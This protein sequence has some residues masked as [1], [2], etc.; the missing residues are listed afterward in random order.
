MSAGIADVAGVNFPDPSGEYNLPVLQ[1]MGLSDVALIKGYRREQGL[2]VRPDSNI[3]SLD[4]V[5]GKRLINRNRGS[6]TRALLDLKLDELAGKKGVSRAKLTAS[7]EGYDSGVKTHGAV[8]EAVRNGKVDVGFGLRAAAEEAGLK[9]IPLVVEDFDLLVPK[10]LVGIDEIKK[11]L[12]CLSSSE[13]AERLPIGL[14][15]YEKTG[16]II[17]DTQG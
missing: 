17:L 14:Q 1:R 16:E 4:D 2:I 6:G 10:D 3:S 5:I 9:F 12:E 15:V 8:C 7:I 13:F 11:L